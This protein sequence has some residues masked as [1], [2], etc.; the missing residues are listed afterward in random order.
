MTHYDYIFTDN[1]RSGG[2]TAGNG[3]AEYLDTPK[4]PSRVPC[5]V[6]EVSFG[7]F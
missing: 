2:N 3:D 4:C 5:Q 7:A 1:Q 6:L